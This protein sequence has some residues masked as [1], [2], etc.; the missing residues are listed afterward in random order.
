MIS[1]GGE[2]EGRADPP[3]VIFEKAGSYDYQGREPER[4]EGDQGVLTNGY[5]KNK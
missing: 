3:S 1:P 4:S 5:R 2:P